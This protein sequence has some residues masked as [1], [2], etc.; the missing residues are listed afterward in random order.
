LFTKLTLAKFTQLLANCAIG[1]TALRLTQTE[2]KA[3]AIMQHMIF[4][5]YSLPSNGTGGMSLFPL[6]A[7][8]ASGKWIATELGAN[9]ADA[10]LSLGEGK[11]GMALNKLIGSTKGCPKSMNWLPKLAADFCTFI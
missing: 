7:V 8:D 4:L 11:C 5:G 3:Q 10:Q 9:K 2:G 6:E 1:L